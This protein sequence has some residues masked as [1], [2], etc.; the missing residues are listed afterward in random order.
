MTTRKTFAA[1]WG[2]LLLA[3]LVAAPG[4]SSKSAGTTALTPQFLDTPAAP[5][6]PASAASVAH[7]K[8]LYDVNCVQCQGAA[9]RGDGYG[10]PF[11]V[12]PPRDFT[13]GQFKFRTTSSGALP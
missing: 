1:G 5:H 10:A 3:G 7:G 2:A 11:Q 9:G 12:P 4:C 8:Q 6:P 13:A